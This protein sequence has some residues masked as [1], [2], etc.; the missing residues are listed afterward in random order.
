MTGAEFKAMRGR[1]GMTQSE[2]AF[3]LDVAVQTVSN[4]ECGR[5]RIPSSAANLVASWAATV[6]DAREI[7]L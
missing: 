6:I 4:W 1:A 3:R 5:H 7:G 2:L